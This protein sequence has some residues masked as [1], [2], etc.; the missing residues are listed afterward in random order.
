M[1]K[2]YIRLKLFRKLGSHCG[3]ELRG[4][5]VWLSQIRI[6]FLSILITIGIVSNWSYFLFK[7]KYN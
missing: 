3:F 2:K 7:L 1:C 6:G 4:Y 5:E